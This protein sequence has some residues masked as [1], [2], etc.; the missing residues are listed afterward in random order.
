MFLF[1]LYHLRDIRSMSSWIRPFSS[2]ARPCRKMSSLFS[3]S[4]TTK[5]G[6][7]KQMS[8][9]SSD[10]FTTTDKHPSPHTPAP[11]HSE[12]KFSY[13]ALSFSVMRARHTLT[14]GWIYTQCTECSGEVIKYSRHW[15]VKASSDSDLSWESKTTFSLRGSASPCRCKA[16]SERWQGAPVRR[17]CIFYLPELIFSLDGITR[18]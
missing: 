6:L 11:P 16:P 13:V 10:S 2:V 4:T 12:K 5:I 7:L 15:F 8:G 14:I 3:F 17:T 9:L 1:V 18:G